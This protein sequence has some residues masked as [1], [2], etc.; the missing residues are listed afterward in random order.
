MQC[1]ALFALLET[2]HHMIE[3]W[4]IAQHIDSKQLGGNHD[5]AKH[6]SQIRLYITAFSLLRL[7]VFATQLVWN[8]N[9]KEVNE[10]LQTNWLEMV[11]PVSSPSEDIEDL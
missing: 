4:D 5:D 3:H 2:L 10:Y 6:Q 7:L 1:T 9:I 11:V 8:D